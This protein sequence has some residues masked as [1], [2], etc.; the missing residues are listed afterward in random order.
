MG[1]VV[2]E[3]GTGDGVEF[4]GLGAVDGLGALGAVGD[5]V[6]AGFVGTGMAGV[7]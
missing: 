1:L 4:C 6:G 3:V 5:V 7:T 2:S